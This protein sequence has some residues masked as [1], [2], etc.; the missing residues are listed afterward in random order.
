D[1]RSRYAQWREG[2]AGA[3]LPP[4]LGEAITLD[5]ES[6]QSMSATFI[7]FEDAS[8]ALKREGKPGVD[9][10]RYHTISRA[11]TAAGP[12]W[13]GTVLGGLA[14]EGRLPVRSRVVV[15]DVRIPLEQVGRLEVGRRGRG[16]AVG[17]VVGLVAD[18]VVLLLVSS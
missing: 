13:P 8:L 16:K 2:Q 4:A 15:G 18:L 12:S 11:S 7:G 17:F 9:L 14:A 1:Y 10:V 6:G 5:L 3:S